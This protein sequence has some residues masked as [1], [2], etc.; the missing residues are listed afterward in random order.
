MVRA[1]MDMRHRKTVRPAEFLERNQE[2]I[3][4]PRTKRRVSPT[5]I[6]HWIVR[7][8]NR[9]QLFHQ[10]NDYE[11][12]E[13]LLREY[14]GKFGITV[15]HYCYMSNHVHLLIKAN[16]LKDLAGFSHYVQRRYAYYYCKEHQW[17]GGVFQRRYR[18]HGIEE[19]SY[20]LECGRYIERNPLK[21]KVVK[22]PEQYGY[23]SYHYYA[24]GQSSPLI[25][26]SPAYL[27]L[28]QD[29][30]QRKALYVRYITETRIQEEMAERGL[31]LKND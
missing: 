17:N 2:G 25:T 19:E 6:Y 16:D 24:R 10:K 18:S 14:I 23:S 30:K 8:L 13:V 4:M 22:R 9:K 1:V 29:A 31:I 7:G 12:F 28:S 27:A 15:Y 21:A 20:L 3:F 26:P 5:G 11:H